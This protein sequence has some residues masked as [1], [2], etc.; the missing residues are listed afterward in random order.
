MSD[1]TGRSVP[2]LSG[3]HAVPANVIRE[4]GVQ[5]THS[6]PARACS[7]NTAEGG[8]ARGRLAEAQLSVVRSGPAWQAD[9]AH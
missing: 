2:A 7:G 9:D 5:R 3:R 1:V 8:Q 4:G 6:W